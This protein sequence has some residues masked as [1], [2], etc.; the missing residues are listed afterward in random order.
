MAFNGDSN[1][2]R[3]FTGERPYPNSVY[4][5]ATA[6]TYLLDAHS[7]YCIDKCLAEILRI[8]HYRSIHSYWLGFQIEK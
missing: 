2:D 7:C 6:L 8:G 5:A 1:S 4:T 3:T